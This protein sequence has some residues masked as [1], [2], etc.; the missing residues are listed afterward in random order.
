MDTLKHLTIY[1]LH[2]KL[3]E[4][5][6]HHVWKHHVWKHIHECCKGDFKIMLLYQTDD[7]FLDL[8]QLK[9][10]PNM[11]QT[12][13]HTYIHT[14]TNLEYI[15]VRRQMHSHIHVILKAYMLI[16]VYLHVDM[17][18]YLTGVP[19]SQYVTHSHFTKE[20]THKSI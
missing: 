18:W 1:F 17:C 14:V 20:V 5:R 7:Y 11:A 13:T 10:K 6:K 12:H 3:P 16:K 8:S 2:I 15:Y 9:G 4:N 19:L